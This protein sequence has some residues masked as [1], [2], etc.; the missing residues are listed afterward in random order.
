MKRIV[1]LG[2]AFSLTLTMLVMGAVKTGATSDPPSLITLLK[3]YRCDPAPCWHGIALM[4]AKFRDGQAII[5]ADKTLHV[6]KTTRNGDFNAVCW[7]TTSL[8]LVNGCFQASTMLG[9]PPKI[10]RSVDLHVNPG[11]LQ[12]GD[13]IA[14]YGAPLSSDQCTWVDSEQNNVHWVRFAD[15][16]FVEVYNGAQQL[17]DPLSPTLT[18]IAISYRGSDAWSGCTWVGF[19]PRMTDCRFAPVSFSP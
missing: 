13:L 3:T 11:D 9:Q 18:V 6:T 19:T 7:T 2:L 8:P 1:T 14:L 17:C 12:L 4:N 15:D 10:Y 5:E 16:I